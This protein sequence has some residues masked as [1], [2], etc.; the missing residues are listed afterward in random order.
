MSAL[1]QARTR[2][3]LRQRFRDPVALKHEAEL[4]WWLEKW[5]PVIRDG[6]LNPGDALSFLGGETVEPTY[7]GRRW[8]QAR[9]EVRRVLVEAGIGDGR[10]F[11]GKVVVDIGPGPLGFPDACPARV[12]IGVDPLAERYAQAGL[13]LPDSPALYLSSDAES[14]PLLSGSVDVALV[15]NSLD[16][17]D[18]P[19]QVL[20]EAQRLLRPGATLIVNV[21][22]DHE[23]TIAEP[24]QLTV[25]DLHGALDVVEIVSER[26]LEDKRHGEDGRTAILV[27]RRI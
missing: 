18:D 13:L 16:H 7:L 14:I 5:D 8:Q 17:V 10:F 21:D 23:P 2:L 9:A 12:S 4:S 24:R 27:A 20:A 1:S 11:D 25:S 3:R 15:R 22:L 26:V 19:P 6:G